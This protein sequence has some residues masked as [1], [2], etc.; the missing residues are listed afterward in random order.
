MTGQELA[1]WIGALAAAVI[2]GLGLYAVF[3]QP[4]KKLREQIEAVAKEG[5]EAHGAIGSN[6]DSAVDKLTNRIDEVRKELG[7]QISGVRQELSGARQELGQLQGADSR[8]T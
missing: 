4:V 7:G 8:R 1:T 5:R 3:T 6:I 2:A